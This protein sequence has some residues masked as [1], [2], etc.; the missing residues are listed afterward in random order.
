MGAFVAIGERLKEERKRLGMTQAVFAQ[1]GG[2]GL[3]AL[4]LYEGDEREPG[5]LFLA[6]IAKH[7]ADV[8]YIVTGVR[9]QPVPPTA[10]LEP[11]IQMLVEDYKG[12][13]AEGKKIIRGVALQAAQAKKAKQRA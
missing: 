11:D 6:A 8:Q 2:I 3:S 10:D 9:G 7:G 5:A 13:D 4:K 12:A 1:M